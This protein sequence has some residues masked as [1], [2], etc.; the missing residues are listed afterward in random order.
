MTVTNNN[1]GIDVH[2]NIGTGPVTLGANSSADCL[3]T[4]GAITCSFSAVGSDVLNVPPGVTRA[5]FTVV[6]A[7]GGTYT[8]PVTGPHP[9]APAGARPRRSR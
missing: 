9:A 5:S 6:G 2:G 7:Q 1:G 3:A 4:G 8:S